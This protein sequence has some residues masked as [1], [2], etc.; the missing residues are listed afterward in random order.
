MVWKGVGLVVG[1]GASK[2]SRMGASKGSDGGLAVGMD[3]RKVSVCGWSYLGHVAS[4]TQDLFKT[5][6]GRSLPPPL[7][8]L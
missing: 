1:M 2:V 5:S 4:E 8:F 3:A 7:R 6:H